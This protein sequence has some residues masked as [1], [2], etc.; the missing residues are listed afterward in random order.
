MKIL[1][2]EDDEVLLKIIEHRLR[3]SGDHQVLTA[4]NGK[5]ARQLADQHLPDV[6]IT[7]ML[8]PRYSGAELINYLREDLKLPAYIIAI[9]AIG[10]ETFCQ[11]ALDLGADRFV[12]KPF[13]LESFIA[14]VNSLTNVAQ[15][16]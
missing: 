4:L 9:S 14:S 11:E 7:D 2:A 8:M 16:S 6:I 3:L 15:A 12:A 5:E 13:D 10:T 1:L